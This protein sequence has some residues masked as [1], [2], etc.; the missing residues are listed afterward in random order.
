FFRVKTREELE[1]ASA[2]AKGNRGL[3]M[4]V[5]EY[6]KLT[7]SE[8]RQ[9]IAEE[10]EKARRDKIAMLHYARNEGLAQGRLEGEAI[11]EAR[12]VEKG[13]A[14]GRMQLAA[15]LKSGKTLDE[16]LTI[17]QAETQDGSTASY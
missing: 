15:L 11:G 3:E 13:E 2:A 12:G 10:K 1:A 8:R 16:A 5:A 7:W 4:A 14:R 9:M 17:L 6:K